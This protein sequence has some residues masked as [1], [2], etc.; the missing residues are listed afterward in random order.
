LEYILR[1]KPIVKT[2]TKKV[3]IQP[4]AFGDTE[5]STGSN[6]AL[7]HWG[8]LLNRIS[9][10][11]YLEYVPHS[12]PY[13]RALYDQVFL[14]IRRSYLHM[15][16]NRNPIFPYTEVLKW[17]IGHTNTHKCLINDENGECVGVFLLIEV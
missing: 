16:A 15:V 17:L 7:L 4:S 8:Y 6:M 9:Q 10:E 13:V 12:D 1:S 5:A 14:N 2:T 11:E 3:F